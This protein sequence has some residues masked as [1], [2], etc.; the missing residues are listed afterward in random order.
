MISLLS[1]YINFVPKYLRFSY[2]ITCIF[3]RCKHN[4]K[5]QATMPIQKK[6]KKPIF[7]LLSTYILI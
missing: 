6:K 4:A 5:V 7:H 3:H 2:V 1:N